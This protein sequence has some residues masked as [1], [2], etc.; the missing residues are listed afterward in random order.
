MKAKYETSAAKANQLPAMSMPELA[1]VGRS[2]VG[3]SSLLNALLNYK[4]LARTSRTPGRTQMANF[5]SVNDNL[6][7][8]DLPGYGFAATGNREHAD[9]QE[10]MD[11]YLARPV[12]SRF[13]FV[14]DARR[15]LDDVDFQLALALSQRGPLS[16]IITKID[17]LSRSEMTQRQRFI[18]NALKSKGVALKSTHAVSALKKSGLDELREN[19]GLTKPKNSSAD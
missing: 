4:G 10:L 11:A 16:L 8:V 5:F 6:Y 17:K 14:W 12:I 3:K 9:W 18:E 13:L 15:D 19:L 7:F 2:N 1:F